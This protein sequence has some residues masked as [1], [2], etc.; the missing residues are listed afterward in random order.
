MKQSKRNTLRF[1]A[2]LI[3]TCMMIIAGISTEAS[4]RWLWVKGSHKG[5]GCANQRAV[6]ESALTTSLSELAQGEITFDGQLLSCDSDRC[7]ESRLVSAGGSLA[8]FNHSQCIKGRLDYELR[9]VNID[10]KPLIYLS[11]VTDQMDE[12]TLRARA[13]KLAQKITKGPTVPT[14]ESNAL[15]NNTGIGLR[16]GMSSPNFAKY[17]RSGIGTSIDYDRRWDQQTKL[18]TRY[19]LGYSSQDSD[20]F[21]RQSIRLDIG[22][23]YLP[24]SRGVSPWFGGGV[25]LGYLIHQRLDTESIATSDKAVIKATI[26]SSEGIKSNVTAQAWLESGIALTKGTL[27]PNLSTRLYFFGFG[28]GAS[29]ELSILVGFRWL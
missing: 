10:R 15:D 24:T 12:E 14:S 22:M 1:L 5:D 28:E 13:A 8:L 26:I 2:F 17:D 21:S 4:A 20:S 18:S 9:V 29:A 19:S 7:A 11:S 16:F 27:Q 25:S 6:F 3:L 23:I